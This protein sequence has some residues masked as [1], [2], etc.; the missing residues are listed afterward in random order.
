[1]TVPQ[2]RDCSRSDGRETVS[3]TDPVSHVTEPLC[4]RCERPTGR[5]ARNAVYCL[6]C[7]CEQHQERRQAS[8]AK[9]R[10]GSR[11]QYERMLALWRDGTL[12][13]VLEAVE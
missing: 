11:E 2:T 5:T 13:R 7:A 3:G 4:R 6:D 9:Q 1:M 12:R 8:H 10:G